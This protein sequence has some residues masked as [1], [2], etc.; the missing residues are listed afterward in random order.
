MSFEFQIP[1]GL[2]FLPKR[3]TGFQPFLH[4]SGFCVCHL[5]LPGCEDVCLHPQGAVVLPEVSDG[6][7]TCQAVNFTVMKHALFYFLT[8]VLLT[9]P[10][11]VATVNNTVGAPPATIMLQTVQIPP[12]TTGYFST[13]K[14]CLTYLVSSFLVCKFFLASSHADM[15][16][17][18]HPTI[19]D[20]F[21]L[22]Q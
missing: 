10:Q 17:S 15:R 19:F 5:L 2:L 14:L 22:M 4:K 18:I 13:I 11:A 16:T 8:V 1:S 21:S 7:S 9:P 3:D 12:C 20:G 6:L